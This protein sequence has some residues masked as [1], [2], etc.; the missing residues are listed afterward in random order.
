MKLVQRMENAKLK[1]WWEHIEIMF[2]F[3]FNLCCN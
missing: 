3:I 1:A 2:Q